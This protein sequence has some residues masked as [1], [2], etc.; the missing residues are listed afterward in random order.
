MSDDKPPIGMGIIA[1]VEAMMKKT[2]GP[3]IPDHFGIKKKKY[4]EIAREV[5]GI[6]FIDQE[7]DTINK[8]FVNIKDNETRAKILLF[9]RAMIIKHR[10]CDCQ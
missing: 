7:I 4:D 10:D 8:L 2:R 9:G 1:E 6:V 5:Y 3:S